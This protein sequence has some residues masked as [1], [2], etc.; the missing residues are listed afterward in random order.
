M[1]FTP[2]LATPSDYESIRRAI[3]FDGD[4]RTTVPDNLIEDRL[5][6]Q[7]VERAVRGRVTAWE[8][9]VDTE[10]DDYDADRHARLV[11]GVVMGAAARL[12]RLWFARRA[13]EEIKSDKA[14]PTATTWRDPREWIEVAD[15]LAEQMATALTDVLSWGAAAPFPCI[16][17]AGGPTSDAEKAGDTLSVTSIRE[18]LWPDVVKDTVY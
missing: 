5:F 18:L 15:D 14:G 17:S 16:G 2:K 4:D 7:L 3:G 1:A 13:G 9:I 6:L 10:H 8:D 12:A 11:D